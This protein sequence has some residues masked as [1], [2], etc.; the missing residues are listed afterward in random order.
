MYVF[1]NFQMKML[2]WFGVYLILLILGSVVTGF[3]D[4]EF[5]EFFTAYI[6]SRLGILV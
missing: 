4:T 1:S 3:W 6:P 2:A 5:N